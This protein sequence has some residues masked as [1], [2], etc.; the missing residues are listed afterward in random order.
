MHTPVTLRGTMAVA[1]NL[2]LVAALAAPLAAKA[3]GEQIATS[4]AI[5][6]AQA[7]RIQAFWTAERKAA[8]IP[9]PLPRVTGSPQ[10]AE[11][12]DLMALGEPGR[13]EGSLPFGFDAQAGIRAPLPRPQYGTGSTVW[14]D[15]PPPSTLYEAPGSNKP[16]PQMALGKL[17]F[18]DQNGLGY[19]CSA[20]AVTT[21]G[22]WGSGN[23]QMVVTAGHC[24]SDGAGNFHQNWV[25]EPSYKNG[26]APFGSW[27][28]GVARVP[29]AWHTGGDFSRDLCTLQMY[30]LDGVDLHD[31]VGALGY[32]WNFPLPQH[33]HAT[34][35][36]QA[37]P[38]DG[39][40]LYVVS[41]SDA[42]TDTAQA[43]DFPFTHGIGNAM[44][45]GS[46][47]G[48]WILAMIPNSHAGNYFNGL[49]SYKYVNP[50]RPLEMFG[51]YIDDWVVD[52]LFQ[53]TAT[54]PPL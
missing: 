48:P 26:S 36:P 1:G 43:G 27:S 16:F 7:A 37:E 8:A 11:S 2:V 17:F 31:A 18:Q 4:P 30:P 45:G 34:G 46:S 44:T 14:Y 35:W 50:D 42:E 12:A 41:A 29:T 47:G 19:V 40:Q 21:N 49:N 53:Q 39:S 9:M 22:S 52:V 24:C 33:Y 28:A 20:S 23:R 25:F 38:F 10:P 15:Y 5:T 13:Q 3:A 51:P 54:N 32:A 6:Q